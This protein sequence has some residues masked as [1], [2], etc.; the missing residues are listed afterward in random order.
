[1]QSTP[2]KSKQATIDRGNDKMES[3]AAAHKLTARE[4]YITT[5]VLPRG[6]VYMEHVLAERAQHT[7]EAL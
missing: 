3:I 1:M 2:I 4:R 7:I 6:L 5:K